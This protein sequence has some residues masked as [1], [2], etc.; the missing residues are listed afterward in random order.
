MVFIVFDVICYVPRSKIAI[1]IVYS[2]VSRD[3]VRFSMFKVRTLVENLLVWVVENLL[4]WVVCCLCHIAAH[5][6]L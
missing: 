5:H 6:T 4:V 2:Q 3:F 1:K